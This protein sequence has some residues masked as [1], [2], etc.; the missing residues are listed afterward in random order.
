MR[1][2]ELVKEVTWSIAVLLAFASWGYLVIFL[3][4]M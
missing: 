3:A 1:Y 4:G 2:S